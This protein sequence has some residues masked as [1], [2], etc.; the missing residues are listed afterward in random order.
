MVA[1]ELDRQTGAADE[2][3][4]NPPALGAEQK[5]SGEPGDEHSSGDD[6]PVNSRK[7][8]KEGAMPYHSRPGDDRNKNHQYRAVAH[9]RVPG[10]EGRSI[11]EQKTAN[12]RAGCEKQPRDRGT[13]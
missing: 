2:W 8:S 5:I 4:E 11:P 10:A 9:H 1:E 12:W 3:P 7:Q 6:N 13:H